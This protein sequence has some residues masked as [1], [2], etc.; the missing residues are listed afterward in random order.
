MKKKDDQK[1]EEYNVENLKKYM[2]LSA[3]Q[4]L[5]YLEELNKFLAAATPFK[6]KKVWEKLKKLGW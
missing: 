1:C 2:Q 5:E 4:K 3:T 6:N